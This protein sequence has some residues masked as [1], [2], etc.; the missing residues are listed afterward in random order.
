MEKAETNFIRTIRERQLIML[1]LLS[2]TVAFLHVV[3]V[4]A[5]V[6]L[7]THPRVRCMSESKQT[8]LLVMTVIR[9]VMA[10]HVAKM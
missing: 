10:Y 8:M 6:L 5:T 1:L 7:T 3:T 2:V 4:T 9:V